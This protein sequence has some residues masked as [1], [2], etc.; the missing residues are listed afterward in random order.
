MALGAGVWG[1]CPFPLPHSNG[2]SS[3]GVFCISNHL[4]RSVS[5]VLGR[6]LWAFSIVRI[7]GARFDVTLVEFLEDWYVSF[8]KLELNGTLFL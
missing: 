8:A 3:T 4:P 2:M 5:Q 1:L 7:K 6:L